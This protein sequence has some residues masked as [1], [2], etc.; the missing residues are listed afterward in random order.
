MVVSLCET[1]PASGNCLQPAAPQVAVTPWASNENRTFAFFV[2]G[3]ANVADDPTTNR[4]N[5]TARDA[6]NNKVGGTGVAVRTTPP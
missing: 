4:V 5:A 3:T 6:Q 2:K 1:D